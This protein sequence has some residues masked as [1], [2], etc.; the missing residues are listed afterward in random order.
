MQARP[1]YAPTRHGRVCCEL[2]FS[3]DS[4]LVGT[5]RWNMHAT[6]RTAIPLPAIV[7]A[8]GCGTRN[9][10]EGERR[11]S[12]RTAAIGDVESLALSAI[13][14]KG[15]IQEGNGLRPLRRALELIDQSDGPPGVRKAADD[16]LFV[17]KRGNHISAPEF[18]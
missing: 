11:S 5:Q 17:R 7:W 8:C 6:T 12:V 13:D 1:D 14:H 9:A 18:L 2:G 15:A 3:R 4:A 16:E 10:P